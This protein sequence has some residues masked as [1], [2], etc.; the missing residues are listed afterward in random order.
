LFSI[1][2]KPAV[3]EKITCLHMFES[4]P[5]SKCAV[6]YLLKKADGDQVAIII[7][8]SVIT[9]SPIRI[10][11]CESEVS[12][13]CTPG[14]DSLIIAGSVVGSLNLYDLKEFEMGN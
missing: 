11:R 6:S 13:I 7:V 12:A 8:F 3:L 1:N 14:D 4:S 2:Q 5:Q 9:N 10:L